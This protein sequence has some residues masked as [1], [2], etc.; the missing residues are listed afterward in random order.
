MAPD[1]PGD[2]RNNQSEVFA[3][4]ALGF[5]LRHEPRFL[6]FF[7]KDVCSIPNVAAASEYEIRCQ[8]GHKSD[9]A[10]I[11]PGKQV[12]VVETKINA[13]LQPKQNPTLDAFRAKSGYGFQ[14]VRDYKRE[15]AR[16]YVVLAKDVSSIQD[17]GCKSEMPRFKDFLQWGALATMHNEP[18]LVED[19]LTSLGWLG[20]SELHL[21]SFKNMK[22]KTSTQSAAKMFKLL[23]GLAH[24]F[25]LDGRK[26]L[27][28]VNDPADGEYI[29]MNIPSGGKFTKLSRQ[30]GKS[31][32]TIGWFGYETPAPG[33]PRITVWLYST[34]STQRDTEQFVKELGLPASKLPNDFAVCIAREPGSEQDDATWFQ[35]VL[36]KLSDKPNRQ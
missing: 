36:D 17:G 29:G 30:I 26:D 6:R 24:Q 11:R 35:N 1:S 18:P 4:A 32:K 25:K 13:A 10:I 22:L 9:L 12:V 14:I 8:D 27:W 21:R 23:E 15:R 16:F 31:V 19:L 34:E 2:S 5:A 20:V 7:L 33:N 3:V 28:A